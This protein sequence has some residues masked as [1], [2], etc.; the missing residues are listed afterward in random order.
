MNIEIK[1][2]PTNM[3]NRMINV[4]NA[5][6]H[7]KP[8][9][10]ESERRTDLK[11]TDSILSMYLFKENT[12]KENTAIE[13]K[14][15]KKKSGVEKL[16]D[17]LDEKFSQVRMHREMKRNYLSTIS[18]RYNPDLIIGASMTGGKSDFIRGNEYFMDQ[19]KEKVADEREQ[20]PEDGQLSEID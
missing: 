18:T 16:K 5:S 6:G 20:S 15:S 14:V 12:K 11:N 2:A 17:H 13:E 10:P 4:F 19:A 7:G 3:A 8:L 9:P 1:Q